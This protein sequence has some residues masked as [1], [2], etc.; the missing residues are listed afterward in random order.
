MFWNI[1]VYYRNNL[2]LA[3]I[4]SRIRGSGGLILPSCFEEI[5]TI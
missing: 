1:G 2:G 4:N 5:M 3:S